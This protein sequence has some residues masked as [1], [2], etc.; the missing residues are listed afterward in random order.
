MLTGKASFTNLDLSRGRTVLL[1]QVLLVVVCLRQ[2]YIVVLCHSLT[3]TTACSLSTVEQYSDC[4]YY[5]Y[6]RKL[7]I[8][9]LST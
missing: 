9:S 6:Y 3:Q 1:L 4:T 8:K 5:L 2:D 7:R